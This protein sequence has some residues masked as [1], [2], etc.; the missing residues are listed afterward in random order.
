MR[1]LFGREWKKTNK[2]TMHHVN[3]ISLR[4]VAEPSGFRGSRGRSFAGGIQCPG[5]RDQDMVL[6][7]HA[8]AAVSPGVIVVLTLLSN[9]DFLTS[10]E[11]LW[12][13]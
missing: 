12:V 13:F 8:A 7:L 6:V 4:A 3:S 10:P 2:Q 11:I 9:P 1:L 5:A